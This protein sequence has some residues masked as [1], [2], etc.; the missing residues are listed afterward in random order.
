MKN[1][2][3]IGQVNDLMKRTYW[4]ASDEPDTANQMILAR[5]GSDSAEL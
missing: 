4:N 1:K 2:E 5:S 3:L